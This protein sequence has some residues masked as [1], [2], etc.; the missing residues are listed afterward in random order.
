MEMSEI[1]RS[2]RLERGLT[3]EQLGNLIGVQKSAIRKYESGV[4]QNMK[5]SSIQKL[6][7]FFHVSPAYLMG[8]TNDRRGGLPS[9]VYPVD[10][11]IDFD[12]LGTISAGYGGS[13]DEIPTGDKIQIPVSMLKGRKASEF[14]TLRV[15]GNSMYPRLLEN[16]VVLCLRCN[17]VDSGSLAVVLYNGDEATVKKVSYVNGEN[18]LDLIPSN[19]EY[20]VKRIEG[21]DLEMCKILG[22]VVKLIRD[23]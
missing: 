1:I 19:P 12:I 18:W 22:L 8:F 13:I 3:Q 4:V 5:R 6:A 23:L 9:E 7:E 14:F 17:S 16:D 20:P 10:T 2:L 11:L 15:K 21:S